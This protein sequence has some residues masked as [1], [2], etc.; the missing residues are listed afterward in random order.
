MLAR[1]LLLC[2]VLALAGCGGDAPT[3]APSPT[4]KAPKKLP[5]EVEFDPATAADKYKGKKTK[6]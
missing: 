6:P 1:L 4:Q 2:A 5:P 3:T